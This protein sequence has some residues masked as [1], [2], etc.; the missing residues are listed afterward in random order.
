MSQAPSSPTPTFRGKLTRTTLLIL[1]PISVIPVLVL[2]LITLQNTNRL[3]ST[4]LDAQLTRLTQTQ[5]QRIEALANRQEALMEALLLDGEFT[6]GLDTLRNTGAD[7]TLTGQQMALLANYYTNRDLQP[8]TAFDEF[9]IVL[10]DQTV[11]AATVR[12]WNGRQLDL[13]NEVNLLTQAS[14]QT[15]YQLP[16]LLTE[17]F[18]TI[19]TQPYRD[20]SGQIVATLVGLT[21]SYYAETLQ[22]ASLAVDS[23]RAYYITE[24]GDYLGL[25]EDGISLVRLQ[26]GEKQRQ[27]LAS[28][29]VDATGSKTLEYR[30]FDDQAVHASLQWLPAISSGLVVEVPQELIAQ[31]LRNQSTINIALLVTTLVVMGL[32]IYIGARQIVRP[33]L[34]VAHTAQA[35]AEGNLDVRA[36]VQRRDEIGLL[37]H[38]FNRVADRLVGLYRSLES[39]VDARSEQ[40]RTA[41]EVAQIATSATN[42]DQILRRTVALIVERFGY[43]HAGIYL[44]DRDQ[45]TATLR[46]AH[47]A[48]GV[49]PLLPGFEV[50]VG[51]HSIIGWVTA[52]NQPWV[53]NDVSQDPYYMPHQSLPETRSE[54]G[55]PLSV[56]GTVLGVLDVQSNALETFDEAV[57]ATLQTLANQIASTLQN[58]RLLE[59]T[60]SDLQATSLLYEASHNISTAATRTEIYNSITETIHRLPYAAALFSAEENGFRAIALADQDGGSIT[61]SAPLI[62]ASRSQLANVFTNATT[63]V[64]KLDQ[65]PA[66]IPE[67]L[68]EIAGRLGSA[69]VA[70]LPIW[71][72]DTLNGLLLVGS[73]TGQ[74]LQ[75]SALEPY[76]SVLEIAS[77][78]LVKVEALKRTTEQL[79]ELQTINTVSQSISTQTDLYRLYEVIHQQIEQMMG[80][81][82]F[83]IALY[84]AENEMIQIPYMD[85]G[86]GE[87]VSPPPFPLGQGLTSILI[88]TRQPLMIVEDSENRMRALGAIM[89]GDPAKSWLGV[90][91]LV[92]GNVIG[93]MIVQDLQHELRFNDDDM[94]LMMTLAGQVATAVDNAR[95]LS[96]TQ[97]AAERDR[98]LFEITSKIRRAS[99]MQ[100]ILT[101]TTEELTRALNL[102]RAHIRLTSEMIAAPDVPDPEA[103]EEASE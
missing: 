7:S 46:A 38:A 12:A 14:S 72:N 96:N 93:A 75:P 101:I 42:L 45:Q 54:V 6:Q 9:L 53:A 85:D 98:A 37:A 48:P 58:M 33:I 68:L 94:R 35:F 26:P 61:Q 57:V 102:R 23:G 51:S 70:L 66:G 34:E 3:L 56:G 86:S 41:A 64:F 44:L 71:L 83:L 74:A 97:A 4:Q 63:L 87:I 62:M 88:R 40:I 60:R 81:V 95:L 11:L 79:S 82:N 91:L 99:D 32:A 15:G 50:S 49:T 52:E 73:A 76:T 80:D 92:G 29:L 18:H 78:A 47:G 39:L 24:A 36:E 5:S 25:G 84:D 43:Y 16:P 67:G 10:P 55:L 8:E 1:L 59:A 100:S 17:Q 90:P 89:I 28:H 21:Y 77:T 20:T 30:S 69:E 27:L 103:Q 2:G 19:T 65:P 22:F 31:S 13:G